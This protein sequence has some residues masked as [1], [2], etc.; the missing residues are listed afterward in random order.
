MP[1][2]SYVATDSNNNAINGTVD[3]A[4][5][6]AVLAALTKQGL[7]PVSI[8]EGE[9]GNLL[10]KSLFGPGKVKSDALVMFTRQLSA[11][12]SAGVPLLRAL[13]S[14]EAHTE[15]AALKALLG[16][17]IKDVEGGAPLAD[18]L[19]K[20]VQRRLCEHGSRR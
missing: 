19:E 13:G 2:F 1:K 7:H 11:M 15:S 3:M 8:K 16:D 10:S 12:V 4:D 6:A 5:R 18:A 17:V 14:L 20:N 9:S